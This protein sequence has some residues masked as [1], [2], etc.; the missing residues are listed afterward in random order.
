MTLLATAG[1]RDAKKER[2]QVWVSNQKGAGKAR[3][4]GGATK[5]K[6]GGAKKKKGEPGG[7]GKKRRGDDRGREE[8]M[9]GAARSSLS[10]GLG[11]RDATRA[12]RHTECKG[13]GG[14]LLF[15][16]IAHERILWF[17]VSKGRER[18]GE[19]SVSHS[20]EVLDAGAQD[21]RAARSKDKESQG[22]GRAPRLLGDDNHAWRPSERPRAS[23]GL[24]LGS[25]P[26]ARGRGRGGRRGGASHGQ[27]DGRCEKRRRG[28]G[29]HRRCGRDKR[30]AAPLLLVSR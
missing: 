7:K 21:K 28:R 30:P 14:T 29:A 9:C 26:A 27:P 19:G 10:R 23:S 17:V 22:G 20:S 24:R 12:A 1:D 4:G 16:Q 5:E 15:R 2:A 13:E 25:G 11:P 3:G 18:G 8:G 6:G